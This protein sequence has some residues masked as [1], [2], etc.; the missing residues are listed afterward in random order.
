MSRTTKWETPS[1]GQFIETQW[2]VLQRYTGRIHRFGRVDRGTCFPRSVRYEVHNFF[3]ANISDIRVYT[4][5][6][7]IQ[8]WRI[9]PQTS[10]VFENSR[11]NA[12]PKEIILARWIYSRRVYYRIYAVVI[13]IYIIKEICTR[14]N[15]IVYRENKKHTRIRPIRSGIY[16]YTLPVCIIFRRRLFKID[17]LFLIFAFLSIV[18]CT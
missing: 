1:Y 14:T 18:L 9:H 13:N 12:V 11:R 6:W 8:F 3:K 7:R 17:D 15:K 16:L 5:A 2:A 10:F 4:I